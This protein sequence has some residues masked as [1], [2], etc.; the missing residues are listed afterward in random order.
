MLKQHFFSEDSDNR[1]SAEQYD[2]LE[3]AI[4]ECLE[5]GGDVHVRYTANGP[6]VQLTYTKKAAPQY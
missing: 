1:K 3:D 4:D 6:E 2:L 5:Q